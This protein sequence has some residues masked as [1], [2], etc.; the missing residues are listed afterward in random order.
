MTE[1]KQIQ[2]IY[3]G[4]AVISAL[5]LGMSFFLH[6]LRKTKDE[7]RNP[8]E[9]AGKEEA[10]EYKILGA[11]LDLVKQDGAAVK[12][13]DLNDKVWIA[14][15]FFAV[16]PMCAERNGKR[17]LEIYKQF[18]N[19]PNFKIVCMSVDP[20]AD[21]QEKLLELEKH[22]EVDGDKWW[23]VK[24]DRETIHDYMRNDMWFGDVRERLVP[25]EIAAKGKWSHDMGI[26]IWRGDTLLKKW[27]EGLDPRVLTDLI[28]GALAELEANE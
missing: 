12:I 28:S 19:E 7:Q 21:T 9:N 27:H 26:Q 16:C 24:T 25:E 8:A 3:V 20:E 23:F 17:L 14:A 5:I 22:L 15:Q 11:D 4:V 18:K 1:K 6:S 2:L 13:S 10:G